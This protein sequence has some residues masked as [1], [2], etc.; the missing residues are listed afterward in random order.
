IHEFFKYHGEQKFRALEREILHK[1]FT[2]S[3]CI[4]STGGGTPC[5]NDNMEQILQH[6]F[7]IYLQ[8]PPEALY[9]RLMQTKRVRPLT[10]GLD[11]EQLLDFINKNLE[12][13][14]PFYERS[15]LCVSGINLKPKDIETI[16]SY[17]KKYGIPGK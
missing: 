13:R 4:I 12:K 2:F 14:A 8:M 11:N 1:T 16:I 15:H 10:S 5:F 3:K 17:Y 7:A 6:G 9:R